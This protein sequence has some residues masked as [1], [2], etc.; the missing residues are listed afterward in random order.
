MSGGSLSSAVLNGRP[1]IKGRS[2]EGCHQM[3]SNRI[4]VGGD[5][6]TVFSNV[7]GKCAHAVGPLAHAHTKC[8][9][10]FRTSHTEI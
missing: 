4:R 8:I 2:L 10:M 1:D 6:C 7:S 9:H 5:A 3:D